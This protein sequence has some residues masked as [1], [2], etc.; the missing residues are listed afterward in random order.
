MGGRNEKGRTGEQLAVDALIEEGYEILEQNWR[1][2][3]LEI[4]IIARDKGVLV[5]VEVKTRRETTFGP[6]V[7]GVN[8]LK[9][10]RLIRAAQAYIHSS[11]YLGE[12]RFDIVSIISPDQELPGGVRVLKPQL[13][14]YKDAFWST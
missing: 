2:G 13:N 11:G 7:D 9:I 12:S 14:I 8:T 3:H 10:R 5:F 1:N 6:P 4:D